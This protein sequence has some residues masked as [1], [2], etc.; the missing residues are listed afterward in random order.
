MATLADLPTG[1]SATVTSIGGE[2]AFRRRMM[3]FGLLPGTTIELRRVAPLG[4]PVEIRVRGAALSIRRV[5]ARNIGVAALPVAATDARASAVRD[6]GMRP[7]LPA[8]P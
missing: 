7:S 6:V 4:D 2:R 8:R 5:E 1:A 3:E